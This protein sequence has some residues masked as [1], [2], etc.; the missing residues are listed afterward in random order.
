MAEKPAEI[1]FAIRSL[2]EAL[3]I[4]PEEWQCLIV[5]AKLYMRVRCLYDFQ[6]DG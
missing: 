5:L 1:E 3:E 6:K 4:S 2:K